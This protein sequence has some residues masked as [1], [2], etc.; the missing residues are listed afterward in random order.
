MAWEVRP[1]PSS[2]RF[3]DVLATTT[4][5]FILGFTALFWLLVTSDT[6]LLPNLSVG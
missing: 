4:L 3:A 6:A 1:S 5:A 2:V